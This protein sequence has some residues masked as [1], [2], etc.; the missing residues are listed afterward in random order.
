MAIINRSSFDEE[1]SEYL[2]QTKHSE[3]NINR[4]YHVLTVLSDVFA[5]YQGYRAWAYQINVAYRRQTMK[6]NKTVEDFIKLLDS[7]LIKLMKIQE[8][9][10]NLPF[11]CQTW[12]VV[13]K[14][15]KKYRKMEKN[16]AKFMIS[17]KFAQ[18]QI[19]S[20]RVLHL[21]KYE[22]HINL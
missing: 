5:V 9:I 18:V 17:E 11:N 14:E 1:R 20:R 6:T 7:N 12:A 19:K 4:L 3:V 21:S 22:L 8:K 13:A 15:M 16:V 10:A 2:K